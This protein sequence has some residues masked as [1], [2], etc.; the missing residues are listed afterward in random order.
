MLTGPEKGLECCVPSIS[1][2]FQGTD[3][4]SLSQ[5]LL[6]GRQGAGFLEGQEEH[7]YGSVAQIRGLLQHIPPQPARALQSARFYHIQSVGFIFAWCA[8]VVKFQ[9]RWVSESRL[10][11]R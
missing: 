6:W 11:Q 9:L 4:S 1:C 5:D 10:F 3:F 8:A 7:F 2:A